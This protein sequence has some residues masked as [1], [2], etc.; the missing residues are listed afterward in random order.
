M[1]VL[2]LSGV[3]GHDPAAC[4][5][6]DGIV[7]AAAEE[8]R[9]T[10]L[11]H[12]FG[13][14][15][16]HSVYFCLKRAGI[17][18]SDVDRVAASWNPALAPENDT[19]RNYLGWLFDRLDAF[20]GQRI[21][22][23]EYVDHH[24]AHAASAYFGSGYS[25][26]AIL[27]VDGTGELVA[28]SLGVGRGSNVRIDS[29]FAARE[30]LGQFYRSASQFAGFPGFSEGKF[31]GLAAYGK[32]RDVS[33][34]FSLSQDGYQATNDWPSWL[35]THFGCPNH[36]RYGWDEDKG[37]L[38]QVLDLPDWCRD[39]AATAQHHLEKVMVHLAEIATALAGCRTLVIAGGVG[40][41]CAANGAIWRS[42]LVD[43]ICLSC[44]SRCGY[45]GWSR[46]VGCISN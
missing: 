31:M 28:A 19:L 4:L 1:I 39:L 37:R 3:F 7:V 33:V 22:P 30:S 21:P 35:R 17:T 24:F 32:I 16:L 46:D 15:P 5:V 34:P 13:Q 40:L 36:T 8:E 41:N 20:R 27:V 11:K 2:G 42:G 18:L 45:C 23:V 9:F 10:R 29:A 12:G 26:A 43:R 38:T 44:C 6:Q 25:E 14:V